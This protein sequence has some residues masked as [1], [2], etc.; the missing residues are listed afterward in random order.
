MGGYVQKTR[1]AKKQQ[2]RADA[3]G[4]DA[5]SAAPGHAATPEDGAAQSPPRSL[6]QL[7][8]A[9]DGSPRVQQHAALQRALDQRA[10]P[11][12]KKSK[13]KPA[14]QMKGIAINDDAG[15]E[16]EADVMGAQA[17]AMPLAANAAS[18]PASRI[19]AWAATIQRVNGK[20][21][22]KTQGAPDTKTATTT[23]APKGATTAPKGAVTAAP[24]STVTAAPK[25]T[26]TAAPKSTATAPKS[27]VTA[28]PKSTA[29]AAPKS[30]VTA[31][32]K[33]TAT[34]A[35]KS[36]ATAAPK[37]TTTVASKNTAAAAPAAKDKK[38][39]KQVQIIKAEI[40][41][42][43]ADVEHWRQTIN[44]HTKGKHINTGLKRGQLIDLIAALEG[45]VAAR[46]Q[47][48][49]LH[50]DELGETDKGKHQQAIDWEN[51]KLA[52]AQKDLKSIVWIP[53]VVTAMPKEHKNDP[54]LEWVVEAHWDRDDGY[55]EFERLKV[56][57]G[58][59]EWS[60]PKNQKKKKNNNNNNN[61]YY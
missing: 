30:T 53:T 42:E 10:A 13:E 49:S 55:N 23:A 47:V 11:A 8:Q 34:A 18:T 22:K 54:D 39:E 25:S 60:A 6:L 16:R 17:R 20:G 14:L 43:Q 59:Q 57:P 4:I 26:A 46:T 41:T 3:Y 31:A 40:R 36:T 2:A 35:P 15:L 9:L 61:N 45:S 29:T 51:N 19:G 58:E 37:N 12:K 5:Q 27:T 38:D 32:P 48:H 44:L 28:A 56:N 7:R 21:K 24:K 50:K 52:E 1:A 33:S